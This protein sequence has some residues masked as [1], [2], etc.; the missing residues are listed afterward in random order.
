MPEGIRSGNLQQGH[1]L[2]KLSG[3]LAHSFND[4]LRQANFHPRD[5][6]MLDA[7]SDIF[8]NDLNVSDPKRPL[9]GGSA[10]DEATIFELSLTP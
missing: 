3:A 2:L 1:L 8:L 10:G 4:L 9:V 6:V 7:G 5:S